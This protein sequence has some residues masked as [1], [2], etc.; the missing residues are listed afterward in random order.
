MPPH[1]REVI[2]TRQPLRAVADKFGLPFGEMAVRAMLSRPSL[3]A[4][5]VGVETE[6]QMR[7]NL[8]LFAKGPLPA[9]A[10]EAIEA[11]PL[12]VSHYL[13]NPFEWEKIVPPRYQK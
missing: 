11:T 10:F 4:L 7:D 3:S 1:L 9:A 12:N 5:V 13:V 8:E 2:P 6:K